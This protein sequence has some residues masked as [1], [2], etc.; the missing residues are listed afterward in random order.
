MNFLL[1]LLILVFILP[2][3]CKRVEEQLE[4]FLFGV[5]IFS[6]LISQTLTKELIIHSLEEPIVISIAVFIFSMIFFLFQ[7]QIKKYVQFLLNI[8]PLRSFLALVIFLLGLASSMITA[9]V[10]S[11][12]LIAITRQ[13]SLDKKSEIRFIILCCFSI[14]LGAVLTPIGEPL[15]TIATSKLNEEFFFLFSL[16]GKEII[17]TMFCISIASLFIIQPKVTS[18]TANSKLKKETVSEIIL[19]TVKIYLF[20]MGLTMLGAG[21]EPLIEKYLL[22]MNASSIYWLNSISAFLDNA[23]LAAAEISPQMDQQTVKAILLGLMISGGMLVPGNIPNIICANQL[24]ISFKDWAYVG[25]PVGTI[26]MV[27]HFFLVVL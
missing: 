9:I 10:A 16:V 3:I 11:L 19:R 22:T 20:I 2:F 1:M 23:T 13:I 8:I 14:G 25:L 21:M 18:S 6:V 26:L 15:A 4:L 24:N 17:L 7:K 27:L 12:L 5:G